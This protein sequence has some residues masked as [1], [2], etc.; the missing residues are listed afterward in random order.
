M[1]RKIQFG[2]WVM[3]AVSLI[4]LP[5]SGFAGNYYVRKS[6]GNDANPGDGWGAGHAISTIQVAI[7]RAGLN[8]GAD[9]IHVAA[10]TY[11]ENITIGGNI[12]LY[13]GYPSGGG[14]AR[15]LVLNQTIIDGSGVGSV[16]TVSDVQ[17]V[18][19]DGFVI[20]NGVENGAG[21][22][23]YIESSSAVTIVK[24][25]IKNNTA[26]GDWGG[27]V[28]VVYSDVTLRNNVIQGNN[29]DQHGGGISFFGGNDVKCSGYVIGNTIVNNEAY[30]GAGIKSANA[31]VFIM[32]NYIERNNAR[33][34][35]GGI[36]LEACS[37][38]S[39]TG[40]TVS[41]NE[42]GYDGGGIFCTDSA[43]F[44]IGRNFISGNEAGNWGGGICLIA[45]S[46]D[47]VN[48]VISDNIADETGGGISHYDKASSRIINNTIVYNQGGDDTGGIECYNNS[49]ATV[50]NSIVWANLPNQLHYGDGSMLS[51][52][53][54]D[55]QDGYTG[56]GNINKDPLFFSENDYYL[57]AAS[58]C[59]DSGTS[60]NAASTDIQEVSRPRK[61]GYDMG[62]YEFVKRGFAADF[63]A[64]GVYLFDGSVW[65]G[66]T[67]WN[68]E[69]IVGW[70]TRLFADFGANGL[71]L[72]DGKSWK[73][74][75]GWNAE[76]IAVSRH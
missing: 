67:G 62:A 15:D 13:G 63:G 59:I 53:F 14:T 6:G 70:G 45:S 29:T 27:G 52:S 37:S 5:V 20:Q 61:S 48:N 3:L 10:G 68:P 31:Q 38:A 9:V 36:A 64:N 16:V 76:S 65:T 35:G 34:D 22:G 23:I 41:G 40:N 17:D 44:Y 30:K 69:N 2:A 11:F 25:Q 74:L 21:G 50:I 60:A 1:A 8:P 73:G 33:G 4:F 28:A 24:N 56:T 71:Y 55:I 51:V 46:G 26:H 18:V 39:I 58:P 57:T 43:A 49:A 72:F 32:D 7:E 42:A 19:I 47:V 54:S 75:C 66:I 12:T